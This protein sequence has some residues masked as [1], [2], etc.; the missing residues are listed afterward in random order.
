M[1]GDYT[2]FGPGVTAASNIRIGEQAVIGAG[3]VLLPGVTIGN[4]AVV[5]AG[6][7]IDQNIPDN[8]LAIGHQPVI[9]PIA[10]DKKLA[11]YQGQE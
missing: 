1:I 7:R 4:G 3:A 2:S 11:Y 10:P 5:S 8:H 9:K 6:T